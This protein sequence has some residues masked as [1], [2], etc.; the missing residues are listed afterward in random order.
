MVALA[1]LGG[2]ASAAH[3][4]GGDVGEHGQHKGDDQEDA[5]AQGLRAEGLLEAVEAVGLGRAVVQGLEVVEDAGVADTIAVEVFF[6]IAG[7]VLKAFAQGN[8]LRLVLRVNRGLCSINLLHTL[9][10]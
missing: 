7:E 9:I 1:F 10:A 3:A 4:P 8:H 6:H 5:D 2:A